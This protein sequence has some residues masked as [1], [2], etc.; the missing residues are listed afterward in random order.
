MHRRRDLNV[1]GPMVST[2]RYRRGWTQEEAVA[3]LQRL[4]C[5]MTRFILANIETRRCIASDKQ[6]EFFAELFQVD[7]R[8]LFPLKRHFTGKTVGI[9]HPFVTRRRCRDRRPRRPNRKLAT[10]KQP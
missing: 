7:V 8:D 1:I 4:G 9:A 6:A 2:L 10:R 3:K 5:Y